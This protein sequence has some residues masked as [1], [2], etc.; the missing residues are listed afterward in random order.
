MIP[1]RYNKNINDAYEE[2]VKDFKKRLNGW[3]KNKYVGS[4]S[5]KD[6]KDWKDDRTKME[7]VTAQ[8][9]NQIF[10]GLDSMKDDDSFSAS[11]S[12]IDSEVEN[13]LLYL[14]DTITIDAL[15]EKNTAK[16]LELVADIEKNI[17]I[18]K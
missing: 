10:P 14:R 1:L 12:V 5:T 13:V 15:V 2:Y 11:L 8:A 16:M 7:A 18:S 3:L 17:L 6:A 9:F 4:K